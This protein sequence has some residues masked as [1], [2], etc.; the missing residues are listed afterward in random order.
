MG[1]GEPWSKEDEYVLLQGVSIYGLDWFQRKTGRSLDAVG[2]KA[3]R[4]F[5][6]GGLTRGAYSLREA[7]RRT[8]YDETQLKRAQS[9]LRQKWKRTSP[10]GS[11]LIYEEQLEELVAWLKTDYWNIRHRLYGC[12]WCDTHRKPHHGLGLC[13][14]CY[15][16]YA[17]RLHRGGLPPECQELLE[18]VKKHMQKSD[19]EFLAEAE[20]RLTRGRALA[21][22]VLVQLIECEAVL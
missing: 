2:S 21:E 22:S 14:R 3:R 1:R 13:V 11:F 10:H 7:E 15:R 6:P 16:R 18:I 20:A 8:G 19:A 5:G 9:A 4:L 17:Q 12:L